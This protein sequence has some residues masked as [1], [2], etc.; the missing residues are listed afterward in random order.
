MNSAREH[1][2]NYIV[3]DSC[4]V[5]LNGA[6]RETLFRTI[7]CDIVVLLANSADHTIQNA[8]WCSRSS[9]RRRGRVLT[10]VLTRGCS[11]T[12]PIVYRSSVLLYMYVRCSE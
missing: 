10:L 2:K 6:Q 9:S 8:C 3:C 7:S 12:C 1:F 4:S 5:L 11:V